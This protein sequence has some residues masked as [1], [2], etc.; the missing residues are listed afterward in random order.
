LRKDFP[1]ALQGSTGMFTIK[2]EALKK[3]EQTG[4][5]RYYIKDDELI[6][7]DDDNIIAVTTRWGKGIHCVR[8][9]SYTIETD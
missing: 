9:L 8:E 2:E 5:K 1:D 6:N 7:L 4:Y 3:Y